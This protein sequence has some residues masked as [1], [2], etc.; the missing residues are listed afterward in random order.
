MLFEGLFIC[1]L[2]AGYTAFWIV[3]KR[4]RGAL[5]KE[6]PSTVVKGYLNELIFDAE[7]LRAQ[8]FGLLAGAGFQGRQLPVMTAA[9]AAMAGDPELSQKISELEG[10][11]AA[12]DAAMKALLGEKD[13]IQK[14]LAAAQAASKNIAAGPAANSAQLAEMQAKIQLL[15]GKLSE[16]SVIEDDLANLKRLQQENIQLKGALGG[17]APSASAAA[18]APATT[19]AS[20]VETSAATEAP[21]TAPAAAAPAPAAEPSFEG[22]VSAVEE[23]IQQPTAEAPAAAAPAAEAPT[24]APAAAAPAAEASAAPAAAAPAP[25]APAGNEADL[26]AEFEKM[27]NA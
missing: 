17:K 9:S 8:L 16:Y 25:A 4:K 14:E 7:Q 6:V 20:A 12:Q 15:E 27:L 11:I 5:D 24:A 22:L 18:E 13:K 26:V 19:E 3:R 21:A 1:L 23:T 10:K 2:C